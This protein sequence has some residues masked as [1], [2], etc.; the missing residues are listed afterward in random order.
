[1]G[2]YQGTSF[3]VPR[4]CFL[5]NR[6]PRVL[7]RESGC[8]SLV[9]IGFH[10]TGLINSRGVSSDQRQLAT[11]LHTALNQVQS[12][13]QAAR[14]DAQHL[15]AMSNKQL[16]QPAAHALID[17]MLIQV[18]NAYVGTIDPVTN[19]EQHGVNWIYTNM[20]SLATIDIHVYQK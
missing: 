3:D 19:S 12:W 5:H 7:K 13:L 6:L 11:Q 2:H 8:F 9:Q 14:A 20:H 16:Q 18:N 15:V 1:M 4:V 17:D 10:L